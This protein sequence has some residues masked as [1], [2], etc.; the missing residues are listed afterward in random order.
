MI[1]RHCVS[2]VSH[3]GWLTP[4]IFSPLTYFI[5]VA[6]REA[7]CV[8]GLEMNDVEPTLDVVFLL[9]HNWLHGRYVMQV[10][11]LTAL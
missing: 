4:H 8:F 7:S 3:N 10:S 5:T 2:H 1:G 6:H 9:H 11:V